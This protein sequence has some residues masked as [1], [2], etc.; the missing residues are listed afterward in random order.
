[1]ETILIVGATGV[2]GTEVVRQL[3]AEQKTVRALVR[4]TSAPEKVEALRAMGAE[5]AIGDLKDPATLVPVFQGCARVISTASSTLS[6][7]EGD[8]I[9]TVDR[10][11]Q[12]RAIEAA[13]AAGVQQFVLVSFPEFAQGFPLQD[14]K[15]QVEQALIASGMGYTILRPTHFA[16]IWFSPAL[17]FDAAARTARIF[18]DGNAP[19]NWISFFDVATA[20]RKA[21]GNPRAL[22][23][24]FDLGGPEALSQLDIV[25]AMERQGGPAFTL[26]HVPLEALQGQYEASEDPMQKSFAALMLVVTSGKWVFN[27]D[28][29]RQCLGMEMRRVA[30]A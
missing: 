16:E 30:G 18:G 27:S 13:R 25:R 23:Q 11:G 3:R 6:R 17:G 14:A 5:I 26:E 1:M 10:D 4:T 20:C 19:M 8:S 2:L 28:D 12:L 7:A 15:R 9:D 21:L 29:A 24:C 22:N